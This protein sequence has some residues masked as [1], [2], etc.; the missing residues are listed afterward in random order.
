MLVATTE[1]SMMERKSPRQTLKRIFKDVEWFVPWVFE[2]LGQT[3]P[4]LRIQKRTAG[5]VV[6]LN[7]GRASCFRPALDSVPGAK[8]TPG[9]FFSMVMKSLAVRTTVSISSLVRATVSCPVLDDDDHATEDLYIPA[10]NTVTFTSRHP[11]S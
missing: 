8:A 1:V 5:T 7:A 6:S 2:Y 9:F 4:T 10:S 3:Y 11:G